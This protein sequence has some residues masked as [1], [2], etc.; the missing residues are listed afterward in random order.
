MAINH[1]ES[2]P[3]KGDASDSLKAQRESP[4]TVQKRLGQLEKEDFIILF[5][6]AVLVVAAIWLATRIL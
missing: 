1:V 6:S 5:L 3:V 2:A 4:G